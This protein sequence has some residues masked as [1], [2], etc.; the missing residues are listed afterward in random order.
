MTSNRWVV[1]HLIINKKQTDTFKLHRQLLF[2]CSHHTYVHSAPSSP[3]VPFCGLP[4]FIITNYA[5]HIKDWKNHVFSYSIVDLKFLYLPHLFPIPF[6]CLTHCRLSSH[7]LAMAHY[8]FLGVIGTDL[9][10]QLPS[11]YMIFTWIQ[12]NLSWISQP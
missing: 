3:D 9:F 8:L 12:M 6:L 4:I 5:W 2:M 7:L 10:L 11:Q 1:Y